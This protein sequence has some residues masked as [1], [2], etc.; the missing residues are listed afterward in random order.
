MVSGHLIDPRSRRLRT[1]QGQ[2]DG[3]GV[4]FSANGLAAAGAT[5]GARLVQDGSTFTWPDTAPD[6]PDNVVASGQTAD[7]SGSGS[8][9]GFLGASTWGPVTGSGTITYTDGSTQSLTIGFGDW[10]NGTPPAGG[11]VAI[12]AGSVDPSFRTN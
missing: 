2:R 7:I 3:A 5:A 9:L 10:A 6:N 11:D 1:N 4:S 12:R 8:T